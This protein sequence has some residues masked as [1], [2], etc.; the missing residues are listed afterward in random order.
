[1][2]RIESSISVAQPVEEVFSFL[3]T[4]ESHRKFI[5]RMRELDQTSPGAFGQAGT[6]LSGMLNYFGVRIPVQ[7]EL[8]EVKS[9]QRLAMSGRMGPFHFKDGYLLKRHGNGTELRFWLDLVPTGWARLLSP[10]TGMIGKI[11]AWETLRNLKRELNSVT[12]EA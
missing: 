9:N 5:P 10:F 11:H 3:N 1:M 2:A 4:C 12:L 6:R 7:Y 8:I